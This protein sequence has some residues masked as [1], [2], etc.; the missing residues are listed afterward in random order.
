MF[1]GSEMKSTS[2]ESSQLSSASEEVDNSSSREVVDSDNSNTSSL[3]AESEN[4][5]E[6]STEEL[7]ESLSDS[8]DNEADELD[9]TFVETDSANSCSEDAAYETAPV[10]TTTA[11]G[12]SDIAVNSVETKMTADS[13]HLLLCGSDHPCGDRKHDARVSE[14]IL[15][16]HVTMDIK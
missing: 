2:F 8:N 9:M 10:S 5:S 4:G 3:A 15:V 13:D 14:S 16:S 12:P 1:V 11:D 7:L 6:L